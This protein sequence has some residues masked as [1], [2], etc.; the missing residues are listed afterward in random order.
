MSKNVQK[1][2]NKPTDS[3]HQIKKND[4]GVDSR[5]I[6]L[7]R[8][9]FWWQK[10]QS[11]WNSDLHVRFKFCRECV[12]ERWPNSYRW[13]TTNFPTT[14]A[15]HWRLVVGKWRSNLQHQSMASMSKWYRKWKY[16]VTHW[17]LVLSDDKIDRLPRIWCFDIKWTT[18][19]MQ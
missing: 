13:Y 5:S 7:T 9:L 3:R 4:H 15:W 12:D 2:I 19:S 11:N 10:E 6:G 18:V 1:K 14:S 8:Y 16:M 17:E